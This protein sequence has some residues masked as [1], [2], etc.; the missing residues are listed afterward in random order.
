[1]S[2]SAAP[3]T[4]QTL[5]LHARE[6]GFLGARLR[7]DIPVAGTA[8]DGRYMIPRAVWDATLGPIFERTAQA[9]QGNLRREVDHTTPVGVLHG[10]GAMT[11]PQAQG[12]HR[13]VQAFATVKNPESANGFS[14]D[15]RRTIDDF[16]TALAGGHVLA[17]RTQL[18]GLTAL[19]R[20]GT[21]FAIKDRQHDHIDAFWQARVRD[22]PQMRYSHGLLN[23]VF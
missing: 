1:M 7:V 9:Q 15:Y 13:L 8:P 12:F 3:T 16:T 10:Y 14:G 19:A 4:P 17:D 23:R 22:N 2:T 20:A 18:E 11:G 6:M 21:T 5:T